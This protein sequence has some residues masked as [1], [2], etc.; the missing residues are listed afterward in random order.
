M[1]SVVF[2]S[3]NICFFGKAG[4]N[5]HLSYCQVVILIT[6]FNYVFCSLKRLVQMAYFVE[7]NFYFIEIT[8]MKCLTELNKNNY[9]FIS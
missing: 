4:M 5:K 1:I 9:S 8:H 7:Y 3:R 2:G 6:S